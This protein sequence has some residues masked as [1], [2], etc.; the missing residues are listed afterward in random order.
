MCF[1]TYMQR[2]MEG[3]YYAK[4]S[5]DDFERY[6]LNKFEKLISSGGYS[7]NEIEQLKTEFYDTVVTELRFRS[8]IPRVTSAGKPDRRYSNDRL[9]HCGL[10]PAGLPEPASAR[11]IDE[12]TSGTQ[13]APASLNMRMSYG[14]QVCE[15]YHSDQ[16]NLLKRYGCK[17]DNGGFLLTSAGGERAGTDA[18]KAKIDQLS[19]NAVRKY[20]DLP[21]EPTTIPERDDIELKQMRV[22]L[23]LSCRVFTARLVSHSSALNDLM[24]VDGWEVWKDHLSIACSFGVFYAVL[25]ML[26]KRKTGTLAELPSDL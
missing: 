7:Q 19:L 10:A 22:D 1:F 24:T 8:W 9:V 13:E 2:T 11:T 6:I 17:F 18:L 16:T 26:Y 21:E 25:Q 23:A 5:G 3:Q 20:V 14:N 4:N 15:N 12:M